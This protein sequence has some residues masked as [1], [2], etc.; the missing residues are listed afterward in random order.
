MPNKN[1]FLK[2]SS[3]VITCD[4][5]SSDN[6]SMLMNF[7][8]KRKFTRYSDIQKFLVK[9]GIKKPLY[10]VNKLI[11]TGMIVKKKTT[12]DSSV[13]NYAL[14]FKG[15]RALEIEKYLYKHIEKEKSRLQK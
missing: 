7:I 9:K 12:P 14:T 6:N 11:K 2:Y 8:K 3:F 4:I 5:L 15:S 13:T 1:N 10:T